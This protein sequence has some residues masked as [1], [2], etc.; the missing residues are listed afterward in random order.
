MQFEAD[1]YDGIS[2]RAKRV[3]VTFQ[4]GISLLIQ[5]LHQEENAINDKVYPCLL[6]TS[7]CV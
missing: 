1:Y 6:Y 2:P 3:L 4:E 5:P 7:R